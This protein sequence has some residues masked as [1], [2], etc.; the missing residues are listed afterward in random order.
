[1]NQPEELNLEINSRFRSSVSSAI[2]ELV[3]I[4]ESN[5]DRFAG[6]RILTQIEL[7]LEANELHIVSTEVV[8]A[9]PD[10]LVTGQG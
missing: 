6:Q 8:E 1:L 9:A 10:S 3:N 7:V 5:F 4:A 2:D